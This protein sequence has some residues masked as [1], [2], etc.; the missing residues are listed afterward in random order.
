[1]L[2]GFTSAPEQFLELSRYFAQKGFNVSA[3]L[4]AGHGT[5]PGDLLK[6]SA[7]DWQD[8]VK[9]A[10]LGLKKISKKIFIIGN[11]FGSNLGFWLVR[12][13]NNEPAGIAT[14]GAPIFMRYHRFLVLRLYTYGL[15][16]KYYRKP[17]RVYKTDYTD[18]S[19]EVTYPIMPTKNLREFFSFIKNETMPNLGKIKIPAL[20]AHSATDP[21]V[22]PKSATYI[23]E[24]LGSDFKR[25]YWFE[26]DF[27][28]ITADKRKEELFE[29]IYN[30]IKEK[31]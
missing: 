2:H 20:V 27:H 16:Q 21:V 7:A 28:V 15:L 1:M 6:T 23:Y 24:H 8:S 4:I 10:Y 26:S 9:K 18:M 12:E 13:F 3:P 17:L 29:R 31:P 25:I 11:S 14:L 19:D 22:H 30:F 5:K